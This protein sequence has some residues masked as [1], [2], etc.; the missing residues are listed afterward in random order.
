MKYILKMYNFRRSD[1]NDVVDHHQ[2]G[3]R[4]RRRRQVRPQQRDS[5]DRGRILRRM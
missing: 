2:E 5:R 4:P 3:A 1:D